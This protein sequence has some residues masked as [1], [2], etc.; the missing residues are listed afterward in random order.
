MVLRTKM[1]IPPKVQQ[2]IGILILAAGLIGIYVSFTIQKS[3]VDPNAMMVAF[4]S[5]AT[6]IV[7][8]AIILETPIPKLSRNTTRMEK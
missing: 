3:D 2:A 1:S 5:I 4:G 7:G 8:I 6:S